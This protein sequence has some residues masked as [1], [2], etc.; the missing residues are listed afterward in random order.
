M[1]VKAGGLSDAD[2]T[3]SMSATIEAEFE[4]AWFEVYDRNLPSA[5]ARQRRI[6]FVAI[7]RGVLRYLEERQD[8]LIKEIRLQRMDD[9]WQE[10]FKVPHADLDIE[11]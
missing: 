1:T 3:E 7:A 2:F 10:T 5:G 8:D 9:S 4:R 6:F 11:L